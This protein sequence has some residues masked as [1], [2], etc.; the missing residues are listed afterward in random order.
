[1]KVRQRRSDS[2]GQT[3]QIAVEDGLAG[4]EVFHAARG[5]E[6]GDEVKCQQER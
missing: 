2:E 3:A 5:D 6:E 1:M 4:N